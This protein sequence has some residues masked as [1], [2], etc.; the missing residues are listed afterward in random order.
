MKTFLTIY[1]GI[2]II[3]AVVT[4]ITVKTSYRKAE[5][6]VGAYE[7]GLADDIDQM[8]IAWSRI[9]VA[10]NENPKILSMNLLLTML[11]WPKDLIWIIILLPKVLK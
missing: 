5:L 3:F 2:G 1:F 8:V 7:L 4:I 6:V 9:V 10:L 11:I